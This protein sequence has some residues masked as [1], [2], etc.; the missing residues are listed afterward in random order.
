MK[1]PSSAWQ[2][3]STK[4]YHFKDWGNGLIQP[5]FYQTSVY[6]QPPETRERYFA[7]D[8]SNGN[9]LEFSKEND[10]HISYI[11]G[12][13][14]T[15]PVIEGKNVTYNDLN[16]AV[17][18]TIFDLEQLLSPTGIGDLKSPIQRALWESFNAA[19]RNQALLSEAMVN[20]Y[21]FKPMIGITSKTD[22]NGIT[23]YYEYDDFGRLM[24]TRDSEYNV[25]ASYHYHYQE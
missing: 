11:W 23:T 16:T 2:K 6:N 15:K 22:Q 10:I 1:H 9:A 5:Y 19:L 21:T 25:I 3:L 20:T 13:Q 4:E 18:S 8:T 14:K 24:N 12:Y 7:V 17:A